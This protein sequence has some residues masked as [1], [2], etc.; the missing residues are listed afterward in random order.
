MIENTNY[1]FAS[2]N[3]S[4]DGDPDT[5]QNPLLNPKPDTVLTIG[6]LLHKRRIDSKHHVLA[7]NA[8]LRPH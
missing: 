6:I 7:G 1:I 3:R 5:S 4:T 2:Y 8:I